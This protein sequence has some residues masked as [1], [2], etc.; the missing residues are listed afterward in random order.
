MA[1][2]FLKKAAE[3]ERNRE[4]EI[5]KQNLDK[6]GND[7]LGQKLRDAVSGAS[8]NYYDFIIA[9]NASIK[10]IDEAKKDIED[11]L[12]RLLEYRRRYNNYLK[13]LKE[14]GKNSKNLT[15][16]NIALLR[17]DQNTDIW[18][19]RISWT[20]QNQR[21]GRDLRTDKTGEGIFKAIFSKRS[22]ISELVQGL[23]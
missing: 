5:I 14:I 23:L 3:V 7:E 20:T 21:T 8:D 15:R 9:L 19:E 1:L 4:I 13:K 11:E 17:S 10:G 22:D 16:D 12:N 18:D 6:L 2:S